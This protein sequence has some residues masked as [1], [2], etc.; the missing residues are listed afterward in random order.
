MAIGEEQRG[1]SLKINKKQV[2]LVGNFAHVSGCILKSLKSL[3]GMC[4]NKH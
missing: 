2:I 1:L 4:Y 3:S